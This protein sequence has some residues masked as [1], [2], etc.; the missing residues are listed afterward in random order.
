MLP[1]LPTDNLYKFLAVGTIALTVVFSWFVWSSKNVATTDNESCIREILEVKI[2][3]GHMALHSIVNRHEEVERNIV[4]LQ[5]MSKDERLS[6]KGLSINDEELETI[7]DALLE[8]RLLPEATYDNLSPLLHRSDQAR[9]RN[10]L[11]QIDETVILTAAILGK[12]DQS[13]DQRES[14][15]I[16]QLRKKVLNASILAER[17]WQSPAVSDRWFLLII[18]IALFLECSLG[19]F[20][21]YIGFQRFQNEMVRLEVRK[22]SLEIAKLEGRTGQLELTSE[23]PVDE[24]KPAEAA[25]SQEPTKQPKANNTSR[26]SRRRQRK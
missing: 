4:N 17:V 7:G 9:L 1:N 14:D 18:G 26:R 11:A 19:V 2:V 16:L 3:L 23:K 5:N 6:K 8:S 10:R 20:M 25:K 21:W 13:K 22:A 12:L 15:E 24:A